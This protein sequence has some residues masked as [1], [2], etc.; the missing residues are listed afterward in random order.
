M[1][2]RLP[3]VHWALSALVCFVLP[4][5][6]CF[7]AYVNRAAGEGPRQPAGDRPDPTMPVGSGPVLRMLGGRQRWAPMARAGLEE[8]SV[9]GAVVAGR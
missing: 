5:E 8:S 3:R 9:G 2:G 7:A 4:A 1:P 6:L